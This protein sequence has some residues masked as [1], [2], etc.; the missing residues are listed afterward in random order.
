MKRKH[1]LFFGFAVLLTAALFTLTAC[2]TTGQ[3][4]K[5][6]P[7]EV[8]DAAVDETTEAAKEEARK[9]VRDGINNIFG[10]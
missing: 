9:G 4:A 8:G 5:S 3:S 2:P 7:D 6:A 10:R 1:G